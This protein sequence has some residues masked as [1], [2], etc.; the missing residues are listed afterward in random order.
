MEPEDQAAT[1]RYVRLTENIIDDLRK[2]RDYG[3]A[4]SYMD[5]IIARYELADGSSPWHGHPATGEGDQ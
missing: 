5:T 2:A 4:P 1:A 3:I